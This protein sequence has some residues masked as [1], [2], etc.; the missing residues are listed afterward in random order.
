MAIKKSGNAKP[1]AKPKSRTRKTQSSGSWL[2]SLFKL[3]LFVGAIGFGFYVAYVDRELQKSFSG[4]HWQVP[5]KVY[6]TPLELYVG[7]ALSAKELAQELQNLGYQPAASLDGPGSFHRDGDQISLYSRPFRFWDGEEPG[8]KIKVQFSGNQIVQMQNLESNQEQALLRLDPRVIGGIYPSHNEDRL[9]VKFA[10][11]PE[12]FVR[13]LL[14]VEDREFWHHYGVRPT[15]ILR[16]MF[17]N[18]KAGAMV[19]GGSTITQQLVKNFFLTSER[20]LKRKVN[21]AIM[22]LL[23]E[24]HYPKREILEAYIN[25]IYLGQAGNRSINGFG[26][27]S[28]FYFQRSLQDLSVAQQAVLVSIVKGPSYYDPRKYPDRLIA[29]RNVVLDVWQKEGLISPEQAIAAINSPL[30]IAG[31][32][33]SSTTAF[34]AFMDLV[35][36]QLKRDYQLADLE[37]DGLKIFT[38]LDPFV[39]ESAE[40]ALQETLDQIEHNRKMSKDILQ[41]ATVITSVEGGDVLAL[42]GSRLPATFGFNHALDAVR[43]IGS[44]V[45]PA[46]YL[47]ALNQADK[48]FNL[49]SLVEDSPLSIRSGGQMWSPKNYDG[50]THGWVPAYVALQNSYNLAATHLGLAVGVQNVANTLSTLGVVRPM[51][52]YPSLLLGSLAMPPIEVA[53]LY[54]TFASGGFQTPLRSIRA[55]LDAQDQPLQRYPIRVKP[56]FTPE[57][58]FQINWA[59]QQVVWSGTGKTVYRY[60]P[61]DFRAAGKTGTTNDSRDSWF[62]GFT[63]NHLGVVWVGRDDNKPMGLT[64]GMGAALIWG[65][66]MNKIHSSSL[67]LR[68]PPT[69]HFASVEAQTGLLAGDD[70]ESAMKL[71]LL[72]GKEP[73][74]G[75]CGSMQNQWQV[76]VIQTPIQVPQPVKKTWQ[77]MQ[78]IFQ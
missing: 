21:E 8:R 4:N 67:D 34:P 57:A 2:G 6:A 61:D 52:A 55:V 19:Q 38:T 59:M 51:E 37:S 46:I 72:K 25:E 31:L 47:T 70:C 56:V 50:K 65:N 68:P 60:L 32:K 11:V 15:S 7:F 9:L 20:K 44:L 12:S 78:D 39:Q 3:S 62:A 13:G 49:G 41:V 30:M 76:P 75:N 14:A 43:P 17:E 33:A 18:I 53:E 24:Y 48:Q 28:W 64:G 26:L 69:I 58:M 66:L 22:A 54:Q 5:A 35:R 77:W 63:N 36:R 71:P 45:K 42:T 27:A 73:A 10:D 16:A 29:R 1:K 23:L 74:M 40:K